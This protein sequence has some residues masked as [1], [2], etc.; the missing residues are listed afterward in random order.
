MPMKIFS[1]IEVYSYEAA[2]ATYIAISATSQD[3]NHL[4]GQHSTLESLQQLFRVGFHRDQIAV[5][6]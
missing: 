1:V 4:Q 6:E 5:M 2:R 3:A